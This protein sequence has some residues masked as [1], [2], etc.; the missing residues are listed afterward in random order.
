MANMER[1]RGES[2]PTKYWL[3]TLLPNTSLK[4]LVK[5]AKHRWIIERDYQELKQELGLRHVE[6]PTGAGSTLTPR[7]AS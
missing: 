1:P 5:M 3:S 4:A 2:E 7:C 6:G